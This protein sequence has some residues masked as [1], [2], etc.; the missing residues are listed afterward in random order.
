MLF[1]AGKYSIGIGLPDLL[2]DEIGGFELENSPIEASL[3]S[4]NVA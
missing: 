4:T 3:P 2:K 1:S